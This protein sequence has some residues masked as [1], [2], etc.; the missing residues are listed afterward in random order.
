MHVSLA[1]WL[2]ILVQPKHY[3]E[4]IHTCGKLWNHFPGTDPLSE[5]NLY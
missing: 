2:F 3:T 1:G 5:L 4:L